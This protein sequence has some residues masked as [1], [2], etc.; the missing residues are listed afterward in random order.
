[1]TTNPTPTPIVLLRSNPVAPDPRVEKEA[2]A[3]NEAGYALQVVAWD[4]SAALPR[5]ETLPWGRV[6]RLAI[7]A[8]YARGVGNFPALL[9]WQIGLLAWLRSHR[10]EYSAIHACDFDTILPALWMQRF[11]GKK[12]VYD[13][14]DFYADH[15]RATPAWLKRLIRRADYAAIQ[16][17]EAV[18][19]VDDARRQQIA[20]SH[21]RRLEVLYNSPA[22][23]REHILPAERPAGS[24]F[25]LA[26]IGLLQTERGL[27]EM[28]QVL[29]RHPEWSLALAG[30]GGDTERILADVRHMPNVTWH[31]RVSYDQALALSAAAD[32]LFATYDPS[33]LNHRYS[34]PNKIFE[35]MMLGKPVVVARD[36][37]MDRMIEAAACGLVVPYGDCSALEGALSQLAGDAGLRQRLGENARRAYDQTYCWD[38]MKERLVAL[39]RAVVPQNAP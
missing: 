20:G 36:T 33:I 10:Q 16:R 25:H 11:A 23:E 28:L 6:T 37:N 7:Q 15:L 34:S 26:Y 1:M 30:F 39:Y 27:L 19:L 38:R 29:Q 13:I 24:A 14:F 21:P 4:R 2:R 32:A 3:L 35:A 31:G 12:V 8:E 9:R 18:I 5:D 17:A 22:D